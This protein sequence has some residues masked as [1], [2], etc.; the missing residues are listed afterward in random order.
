MEAKKTNTAASE[1]TWSRVWK[2]VGL[3]YVASVVGFFQKAQA[4][5]LEL[6][7]IGQYLAI[8]LLPAAYMFWFAVVAVAYFAFKRFRVQNAGVFLEILA[9]S[10][11]ISVGARLIYGGPL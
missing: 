3:L 8:A 10:Y 11:V 6:Q 4:Q 9:I 5:G 1:L 2:W 7:N